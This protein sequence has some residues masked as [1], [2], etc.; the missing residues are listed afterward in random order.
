M[1]ADFAEVW[2]RIRHHA[3]AEFHTI[4]GRPFVYEVPG[5]YLRTNRTNRNLPRSN[6]AKALA[7]MPVDGPGAIPECQGPSY[8]W[9]ILMDPRIRGDSW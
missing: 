8:T 4:L 2:E 3:G 7:V 6:F 9:A 5:N 1:A